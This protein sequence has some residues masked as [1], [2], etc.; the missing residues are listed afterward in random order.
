MPMVARSTKRRWLEAVALNLL[1]AAVWS[2]ALALWGADWLPTGESSLSALGNFFKIDRTLPLLLFQLV[3]AA[4]GSLLIGSISLLDFKQ[5]WMERV[6]EAKD[7]VSVVA[8]ALLVLG[9]GGLVVLW[10][11]AFLIGS[12]INLANG[13]PI[14]TPLV[15]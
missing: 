7:D 9:V 11:L 14:L 6:R 12:V 4:L 8:Q 15:K 1:A 5:T 10:T 2:F 13:V 3:V